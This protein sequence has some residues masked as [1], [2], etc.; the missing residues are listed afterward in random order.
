MRPV[1]FEAIG[2]VKGKLRFLTSVVFCHREMKAQIPDK[3][4]PNDKIPQW[5]MSKVCSMFWG[6]WQTITS[7]NHSLDLD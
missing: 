3:P 7:H 4:S 5:Y 2:I 1:G 6:H